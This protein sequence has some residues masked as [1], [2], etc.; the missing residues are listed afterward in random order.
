[1]VYDR[2]WRLPTLMTPTVGM[3]FNQVGGVLT[4]AGEV[5]GGCES[6]T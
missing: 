1:M 2:Q 3:P 5:R 6:V 4:H